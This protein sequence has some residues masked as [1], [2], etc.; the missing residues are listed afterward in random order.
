[1]IR[2]T[3][4]VVS[5]VL[6]TTRLA[7]PHESESSSLTPAHRWKPMERS[8]T[9]HHSRN[10]TSAVPD[11]LTTRARP[12]NLTMPESFDPVGGPGH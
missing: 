2:L 4:V 7:P 3:G 9:S 12:P 11:Q 8:I 10:T 5:H 6:H 1:M